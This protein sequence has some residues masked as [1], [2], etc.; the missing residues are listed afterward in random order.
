MTNN[1]QLENLAKDKKSSLLDIFKI[2][3]AVNRDAEGNIKGNRLT[4]ANLELIIKDD[5]SEPLDA[6]ELELLIKDINI[7]D[8][9]LSLLADIVAQSIGPGKCKK[10]KS[11]I[12][13]A[14]SISSQVWIN[15]DLNNID[16]FTYLLSGHCENNYSFENLKKNIDSKYNKKISEIKSKSKNIKKE[17]K[18]DKKQDLG[19]LKNKE[20]ETITKQKYSITSIGFYWLF[21]TKESKTD[22]NTDNN[23]EFLLSLLYQDK[24]QFIKTR[25]MLLTLIN[26]TYKSDETISQALHYLHD[27]ERAESKKS[28]ILK[29]DIDSLKK[30]IDKEK[31]SREKH[32]ED[33]KDREKKINELEEQQKKTEAL[34]QDQQ[35]DQRAKSTHLKDNERQVK[36]RAYNLLTEE[37]LE[38]LRLS[39]AALSRERPKTEIAIYNIETII[40]RVEGD[41]ECFKE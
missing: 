37:V 18:I 5:S 38:P 12:N 9:S 26:Q 32:I 40:E 20:I 30:E 19:N 36:A 17:L 25:N 15:S 33:I 7:T 8:P 6:Q 3:F 4:K 21:I 39:L 14:V 35:L 2:I 13:L 31:K 34:A 22:N 1:E 28:T 41:L 11:I 23:I 16:L 27:K 29:S 24:N 10:P